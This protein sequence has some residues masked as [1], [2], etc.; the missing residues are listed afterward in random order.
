LRHD[1]ETGRKGHKEKQRGFF[2]LFNRSFNRGNRFYETAVKHALRWIIPYLALYVAIVVAMGYLF[3]RVPTAFLPEEDQGIL[4]VQVTTPVGSTV[5]RTSAVLDEIR[6]Y[7][8]TQEKDSVDGV[9]TVT[10]SA[11]ADGDKVRV[12]PLSGSNRGASVRAPGAASRPSPR[13]P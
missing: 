9:F 2:G 10:D 7:F 12:W 4:F 1:L 6:D 5:E 11:S 8:L 3:T 13:A